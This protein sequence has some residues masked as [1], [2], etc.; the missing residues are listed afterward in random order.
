MTCWLVRDRVLSGEL[1]R[2]LTDMPSNIFQAYAV[3]P[4]SPVMLPKVR[5]AIDILAANLPRLMD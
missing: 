4:R 2:V 5:L 3:W 1:V